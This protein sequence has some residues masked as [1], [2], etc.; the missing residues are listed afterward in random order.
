MKSMRTY[1][2]RVFFAMRL[3]L[4]DVFMK[5]CNRRE[6]TSFFKFSKETA[7]QLLNLDALPQNM[8]D[9]GLLLLSVYGL[10]IIGY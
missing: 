8:R 1:K 4:E 10:E 6:R 5:R 3:L 2:K 9:V 7:P